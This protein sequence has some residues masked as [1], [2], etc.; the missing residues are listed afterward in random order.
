MLSIISWPQKPYNSFWGERSP[1]S[2][3][4]SKPLIGLD[5]G[6]HS[7]KLVKLE[8]IN[9]RPQVQ[10]YGV[11]SLPEGTSKGSLFES[12]GGIEETIRSLIREN[13]IVDT[14]VACSI[15]GPAVMVKEI[16]VPTHEC[17]TELEEHLA[18]G[19]GAVYSL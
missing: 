13:G 1:G 6:S 5:L 14:Q 18:M 8:I 10:C 17:D 11:K 2:L 12:G 7:I 15:R 4:R 9:E 3:Q 16:H 19:N